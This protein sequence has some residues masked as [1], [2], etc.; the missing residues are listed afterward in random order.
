MEMMRFCTLYA[1]IEKHIPIPDYEIAD[2][3]EGETTMTHL[4]ETQMTVKSKSPP[5]NID[6]TEMEEDKIESVLIEFKKPWDEKRHPAAKPTTRDIKTNLQNI[7]GNIVKENNHLFKSPNQKAISEMELDDN[8]T[9]IPSQTTQVSSD[10][11]KEEEKMV[12][13]DI[14]PVCLAETCALE[15]P[16]ETN[17]FRKRA[18]KVKAVSAEYDKDDIQDDIERKLSR[19]TS[20]WQSIKRKSSTGDDW[21]DSSY[22]KG[23]KKLK[24]LTFVAVKK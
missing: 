24:Q 4:E 23:N 5:K 16:V 10:E 19:S 22:N 7:P 1:S 11:E 20:S 13:K 17:L 21:M 12:T 6:E 3:S 18:F 9:L 8:V 2:D 14:S 15:D